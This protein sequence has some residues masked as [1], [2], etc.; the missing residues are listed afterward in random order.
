MRRSI[1]G[2]TLIELLIVITIIGILAAVAIPFYEG[3]KIRAKLTEVENAM[4]TVASSITAFYQEYNIFPNCPTITEVRNSLGVSLDSITRISGI[5][6]VNGDI[7]VTIQNIAPMVDGK[8]LA[9]TPNVSGDD[10]LNWI[11][12]WSADFP[13]HLRP[14]GNSTT[15]A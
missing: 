9:L 2:F 7:S 14:K 4:S 8:S 15:T 5:S 1:S 6:V 13:L 3:Y 10:S 12:G 11:W